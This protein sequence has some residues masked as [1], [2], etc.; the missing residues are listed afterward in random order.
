[1]GSSLRT[2]G[3]FSGDSIMSVL[4]GGLSMLL[5]PASVGYVST[6]LSGAG[7]GRR[8]QACLSVHGAL[9][10]VSNGVAEGKESCKSK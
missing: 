8:E 7:A 6:A 10:D 9:V 1:M 2:L 3:A 4:P 5:G